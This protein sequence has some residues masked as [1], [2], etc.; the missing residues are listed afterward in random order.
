M[1]KTISLL[2]FAAALGTA[3]LAQA[4]DDHETGRVSLSAQASTEVDND[5]MRATLYVEDEDANPARLADAVNKLMADAVRTAQA[6]TGV[7]LKTG[8]YQ[9]FPVYDKTRIVRWRARSDLLLESTD[10]KA[11]SDLI[12]RLQ[13][14]L[15]L[16]AVNFFVSPEARRTAEDELTTAAIADF[17]RRAELVARSFGTRGFKV[18]EASI[19]SD[20][21]APPMPR[22]MAMMKGA[23]MADAVQA[24]VM[25]AGTSRITVNVNGTILLEGG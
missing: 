19:N 21:A 13:A 20:G 4:H 3:A 7:K 10:F 6:A 14:T 17:K 24:P 5:M 9:T 2:A 12:G 1:N 8:G 18:K 23:A 22:P 11:L 16:G 15:K 25:E